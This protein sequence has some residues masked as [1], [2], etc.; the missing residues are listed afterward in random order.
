MPYQEQ[1]Q[2]YIARKVQS[3]LGT[4]AS[5]AGA[6]ILRT[7]GGQ[8][9]RLTKAS[10]ESNEVR[11]DYM[12]TRGR[13][14][15]Q[16]ST[17]PYDAELSIGAMDDVFE[18][19]F[20]GTWSAADL[21]ITQATMTSVTTGANTIIAAAG[22]WITG[23]LRVGDVIRATGLPDAANN[24]KNLRIVGL[25]AS[26]ITV[27]ETLIV[28]AAADTT[29][30][31]TRSGRKLINPAAGS[32]I[33]RYFTIEEYEIN[34]DGSEVFNDVVW[35][36][37]R[38]SMGPDGMLM[39]NPTW[40]GTG[41]FQALTGASAPYFTTPTETTAPPLCVLDCTLRLNTND[42][43][44]LTALDM[45][46]DVGAVAPSMISSKFAPD[47]FTGQMS[48]GGNF[49]ALRKDL[50]QVTDFLNEAQVTLWLLAA[51]IST[52]PVGFF[53]LFVP[54][55]TLGAV[56]KSALSKEAGP[57]TQAI[58]IPPALVGKDNTGGSF[59][60]TMAVIQVSNAT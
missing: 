14:G 19:L 10:I 24:N 47:V 50:Q 44:D 41:A 52:T 49:T 16:K 45:T 20:R 27:A 32:Q 7:T 26:T 30:T 59:E 18:A 48:I 46:I 8:A 58:T 12:R 40:T 42:M 53:S 21:A 17:G 39:S 3:A 1:S 2:G 54:N 11:R 31:I 34:I 13:H 35:N 51:D 29:F 38:F 5:G 55:L 36:S 28:N 15:T 57:R 9:G 25:T 37:V 4:I 22:S 23:G 43:I 33:K 60:P 56:D 6:T